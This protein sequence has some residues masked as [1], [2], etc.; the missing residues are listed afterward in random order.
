MLQAH[1]CELVY[2]GTSP[3][4]RNTGCWRILT[5]NKL[6]SIRIIYRTVKNRQLINK[7]FDYLLLKPYFYED[8]IEV[9]VIT[10]IVLGY[11]LSC[12]LYREKTKDK[13]IRGCKIKKQ[14]AH[15][16]VL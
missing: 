9:L 5:N 13:P 1:I 15:L 6:K 14:I 10:D 2:Q 11:I 8:Y 3:Q 16:S 7:P 4:L 12:I